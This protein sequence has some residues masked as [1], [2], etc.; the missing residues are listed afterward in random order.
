MKKFVNI[1]IGEVI[2]TGL[3][4]VEFGGPWGELQRTGKARWLDVPEGEDPSDVDVV[5]TPVPALVVN[6]ARKA[7]RLAVI[8]EKAARLERMRT[9]DFT[10]VP[11]AFRGL[12]QDIV[13]KLLE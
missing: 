13:A 12:L 3:D 4:A 6:A 8:A 1:E 11:P 10:V 2:T 5:L 9:F 7:A